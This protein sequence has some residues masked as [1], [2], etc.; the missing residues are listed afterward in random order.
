MPFKVGKELFVD[1][2]PFEY[3][4]DD[5]NS[6]AAQHL[7][8]THSTAYVHFK[9][10][11]TFDLKWLSEKVIKQLFNDQKLR[12]KHEESGIDDDLILTA[13]SEELHAFLE[14]FITTDM[15]NKWDNDDVYS[16]KPS[17]ATD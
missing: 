4:S 15:D 3:D 12:L 7:L 8:K 10:D 17:D 2:T 5:L 6:L 9:D 16:L 13:T 14:K 1:I 11:K